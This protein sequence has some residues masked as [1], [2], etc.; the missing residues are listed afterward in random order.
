MITKRY[1][2]RRIDDIDNQASDIRSLIKIIKTIQN[3]IDKLD[4]DIAK[5]R[6]ESRSANVLTGLDGVIIRPVGLQDAVR[7]LLEHLG[8]CLE[9]YQAGVRVRAKEEADH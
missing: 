1:L 6:S 8:L 9:P 4:L 5:V 7:A 3:V 2:K